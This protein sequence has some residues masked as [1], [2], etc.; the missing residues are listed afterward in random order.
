MDC[1]QRNHWLPP[2]NAAQPHAAQPLL[3]AISAG[4]GPSGLDALVAAAAAG[5]DMIQIREKHLTA[6]ALFKFCRD[7]HAATHD[8]SARLL[9]N[10]RWDIAVAAG[11][12]GVHLPA[13][14]IPPATLRPLGPPGFIIGQSC[15]SPAQVAAAV[16]ADFCVLGPVFATPSKSGAPM[17]LAALH[18]AT[19]TSAIPILALG[20][21]TIANAASC[22]GA[23]AAGLAGIRLFQR[24]A[25]AVVAALRRQRPL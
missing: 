19:A 22:L 17:G 15:H 23:G 25:A 3:Y 21:I 16:G 24:D 8:T 20:G 9:L 13:D 4:S 10:G 1:R 12:D 18:A 2:L 11:L 7:L 14:G 6:R 5:V